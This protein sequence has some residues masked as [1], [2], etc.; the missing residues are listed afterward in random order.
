MNHPAHIIRFPQGYFAE[1][2][3]RL[4][5]D[6]SSEAMALLFA[7]KED[8]DSICVLKVV[9]IKYLNESDYESRGLVHLRPKRELIHECLVKLQN[10]YDID[11]LIDVH[12][13]PFCSRNVAFSGVDDRDEKKFIRWMDK[14]FDNFH[15]ASIVLSRSDYSARYWTTQKGEAVQKPATIRTQ[16][17]VEN[18]P[19]SDKT[20]PE[21]ESLAEMT[22]P[23][24]GFLARSS[25][26]LGLDVLRDITKEQTITIVGVGG[27]GSVIAE[28]LVHSGFNRIHLVDPDRVEYTNLN[29][30]VGAYQSDA[31]TGELKVMAVKRHLEN[32]NPMA[33][34]LA[35]PLGVEDPKAVE[36]LAGADWIILATDNHSSRAKTQSLALRYGIPLISTGVNISVHDEKITDMSG[37]IIVARYGDKLCLNCLGRINPI[38]VASEQQSDSWIGQEL[39]RK[40]YVKGKKVKEPAVK[41]L[42]AVIGAMAVEMLINQYTQ[43][44]EFTPILVYENNIAPNFYKDV[45][46]VKNRNKECFSCAI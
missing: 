44:Q 6:K 28:N 10:R 32:I 24:T 40:G 12:T 33:T 13:H 37:E 27:L 26:A 43:R 14:N 45:E 30:I 38:K 7:K 17:K 11:T 22:N 4:L 46:S 29:R 8:T 18:W 23:E 21:N 42:N 5:E 9:E 15:Y 36:Y 1:L 2:R 31:D 3:S 19:C 34:I 20:S 25:L 16:T 35:H 41:T 39:I